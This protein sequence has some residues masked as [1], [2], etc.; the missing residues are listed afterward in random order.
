MDK[1]FLESLDLL[2]KYTSDKNFL[3]SLVLLKKNTNENHGGEP[4]S[5]RGSMEDIKA[6]RTCR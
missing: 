6:L 3:E 2:K 5:L 1:N 4:N